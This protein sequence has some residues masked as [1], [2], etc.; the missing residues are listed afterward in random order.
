[1]NYAR[2]HLTL[3]ASVQP[4]DG[5][6]FAH[7]RCR[8]DGLREAWS[9][10]DDAVATDA[11]ARGKRQVAKNELEMRDLLTLRRRGDLAVGVESGSL[12]LD[13][14]SKLGVGGRDN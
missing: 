4:V 11:R 1:L 5:L 13:T 12:E 7:L 3:R 10:F 6:G 8:E 2:E 14:K 9:P